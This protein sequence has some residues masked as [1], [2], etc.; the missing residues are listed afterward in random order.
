ML[1]FEIDGY[2]MQ[3]SR[4]GSDP[5]AYL[6]A[7]SE[8]LIRPGDA[9]LRCYD[10]IIESGSVPALL[11]SLI[12]LESAKERPLLK[13]DDFL[14]A[15]SRHL[16]QMSGEFS[17]SRSQRESLVHFFSLEPGKALAVNGPPGTGKTT[18]LQ[19]VI[20]CLVVRHALAGEH[21]PLILAASTNN[22]AVTNI[23]D[24]FKSS[25][26]DLFASRWLPM[27]DSYGLYWPSGLKEQEAAKRGFQFVSSSGM[28]DFP[29][30][31]Q[32]LDFFK[33]AKDHF[34]KS[35]KNNL[36]Y[37]PS[38]LRDAA[39]GLHS[40]LRS[41][42]DKLRSMPS[43]YLAARNAQALDL[44]PRIEAL[45]STLQECE[46][47]ET[48]SRERLQSWVEFQSQTPWWMA[49]FSFL[50]IVKAQMDLRS[51]S[52]ATLNNWASMENAR[53]SDI[54]A[55]LHA[56]LEDS[57]VK[58][59]HAFMTLNGLEAE[60]IERQE[61]LASFQ[62]LKK[63]LGLPLAS[64][65]ADQESLDTIV[66]SRAFYLAI[67]YW[68]ARWLLAREQ[69]LLGKPDF[70]RN[71]TSEERLSFLRRLAM[72]APCSVATLFRVPTVL[73]YFRPASFLWQAL[74]LLIIDEAGQ[75]S[76]EIG[77]VTFAFAKNAIVVGDTLQIEPVWN[78]PSSVDQG[79]IADAGFDVEK[80]PKA[81]RA[82]EGNLMCVAQMASPFRK[83]PDMRGMFLSE[84][85]RCLRSLIDYC[86]DL[87]YDGHLE[88]MR[89]DPKEPGLFPIWGYA[90]VPGWT[91]KNNGKSLGNPL[92]AAAIAQWIQ[93]H[94]AEL[95]SLH[96][97]GELENALAVVAP[98]AYQKELVQKELRARNL[99]EITVG[100]VHAL[101]GAER[102]L[103]I[104]SPTCTHLDQRPFFFDR[105]PH[106]L[107]V[108]VSRAKDSFLVFGD[109]EI[110]QERSG[111]KLPS[112]LL[113]HYLFISSGRALEGYGLPKPMSGNGQLLVQAERIASLDGH[114]AALA[115]S[116]EEAKQRLVIVSPWIT[117]DALKSDCLPAKI[118]KA[119]EKGFVVQ[120]Y[121]DRTLNTEN[122]RGEMNPL[123]ATAR[124]ASDLLKEAG[125][126]LR[127]TRNIH[128]KNLLVDDSTVVLGS[129]NWLSARRSEADRYHRFDSSIR[130]RGPQAKEW[131]DDFLREM[132]ARLVAPPG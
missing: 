52:F 91:E 86:N 37:Q 113:A 100:T 118:A 105:G 28:D 45:R 35:F 99:P 1:D 125:A 73:S 70:R 75:V 104:F 85:R 111:S 101:Q 68:E 18:L 46:A 114:R 47:K 8:P 27:V 5:Q 33:K 66:R 109:M 64:I 78:I 2:E 9:L 110:F 31:L 65:S 94:R 71:G 17:L 89:E 39:N 123:K 112:A 56:Q 129:F 62:A 6:V 41:T 124:E 11:S 61:A 69:D 42:V 22:Q 4:D 14:M 81:F 19:S 23:I 108:A 122:G 43:V 32:T 90:H 98:F 76:P 44:Q 115:A 97:S 74:D 59:Q 3:K 126:D 72:L 21:P 84:H 13:D 103:V 20:A 48:S 82:S 51:R 40:Y 119:T 12:E 16:G 120:V 132:E 57:K 36:D 55:Q 49:V 96:G 95:E 63:D 7:L 117:A 29:A 106:M 58:K 116:F 34:L 53:I 67:H 30:T 26:S 131:I 107:N 50:P 10:R 77:G 87:A 93:D 79:N 128:N 15:T 80:F 130:F 88:P 121:T 38:S 24:S 60:E 83:L 92:E 102:P 54:D 127:W 25:P